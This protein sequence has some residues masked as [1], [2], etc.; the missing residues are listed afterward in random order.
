MTWTFDIQPLVPLWLAIALAV[1]AGVLVLL[2]LFGGVRGAVLRALAGAVL[3]AAL[4]NPVL[5]REERE[6]L[7][8]IAVVVADRSQ[9]Q[10]TG[11]R[12]GLTDA[13]LAE[14]RARI[15]ALPDT[16]VRLVDV[17]SGIST[18]DEG[19]H[20][21]AALRQALSDVPPERY[22]GAVMITDGQI[23]DVPDAEIAAGYD[24]PLHALVTGK[25]GELDRTVKLTQ[26]P[27]FGI[28]GERQ[29]MR[30]IVHDA[31]TDQGRLP[32][33]LTTRNNRAIVVI[34]GI[35]D[36]LRVLLVSGEPHAG[37]RTWRN[38]LKSDP[39]VDLVHF[40]ILRPPEKQD[41]TPI[42]ELSLIAFPTRELFVEKIDEFDLII[43]D[44]YQRRGV[45]PLS[46]WPTLPT[47][48]KMAARC[49]L[50]PAP[51]MPGPQ[52]FIAR[53]CLRYCRPCPPAMSRSSRSRRW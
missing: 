42:N 41:G 14:L 28:V 26:S 51:V 37:E 20:A 8:D 30:F 9:S 38:L 6:M 47:M 21:F 39:S 45:L 53:R 5:L 7:P 10:L 25:P 17:R 2:A 48:S 46:I 23:H 40:T 13:A 11:S 50:R 31:G 18:S 15:N 36:R 33:E 43:F 35:R 29:P 52:A 24:G 19:T 27:K 22:A 34:K 16:E 49:W 4:F 1:I 3:A 32:G 12:T 44:R